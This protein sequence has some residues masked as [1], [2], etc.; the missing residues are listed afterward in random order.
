MSKFS[1]YVVCAMTLL[2]SCTS[3]ER[4]R[5]ALSNG[6]A[7]IRGVLAPMVGTRCQLVERDGFWRVVFSH[8]S[9]GENGTLE[10][11]AADHA[12]FSYVA[13]QLYIPF[14]AIAHVYV[15]SR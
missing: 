6:G 11:I 15:V 10:G 8:G 5:D 2:T 7:S 3:M 4:D 9:G 14:S 12:R 1:I 13:G